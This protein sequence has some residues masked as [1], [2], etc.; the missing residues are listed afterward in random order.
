[1]KGIFF[2][3]FGIT[4][5]CCE[6]IHYGVSRKGE[7]PCGGYYLVCGKYLEYPPEFPAISEEPGVKVFVDDHFS[8]HIRIGMF[9][10]DFRVDEY[11][12]KDIP[13]NMP[14]GFI[15]INFWCDDMKWLLPEKPDIKMYELPQFWEVNRIIKEKID[16]RKYKRQRMEESKQTCA[17]AFNNAG[18]EFSPIS[19]MKLKKYKKQWVKTFAPDDGNMKKIKNQCLHNRKFGTYLWHMFSYKFLDCQEEDDAMTSFDNEKKSSCV[20]VFNCEDIAYIIKSAEKL[21]SDFLE[22]FLDVTVTSDDFSWT[23]TKTHEGYC[24]PYFYKK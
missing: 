2:D 3:A 16:T 12:I 5:E 20:V 22:E 15:C 17:E 14:E 1:M 4:P 13:E 18:I 21:S 8:N 6:I 24:G 11:E 23:Y 19:E 7:F 10:F 9:D